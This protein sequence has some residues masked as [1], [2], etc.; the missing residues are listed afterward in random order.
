MKSN[1]WDV[2]G[3]SAGTNRREPPPRKTVD[4]IL[5]AAYRLHVRDSSTRRSVKR[6]LR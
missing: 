5:R 2:I 6:V 3:G 1:L 4:E